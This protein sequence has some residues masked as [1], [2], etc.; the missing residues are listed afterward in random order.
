M[1]KGIKTVDQW[2]TFFDQ[3]MRPATSLLSI[4]C[5]LLLACLLQIL[6]AHPE[7][8]APVNDG[9]D[10]NV[11][12][13]YYTW[14][15]MTPGNINKRDLASTYKKLA[16]NYHPDKNK[17]PEAQDIFNKISTAFY[18]LNDDKQRALYD[19]FGVRAVDEHAAGGG[20]SGFDE[21]RFA[22][23]IY[24]KMFRDLFDMQEF[25]GGRGRRARGP[26]S[27]TGLLVTLEDMFQGKSVHL[28]YTRTRKCSHCKGTGADNPD[29][30]ETCDKCAG[31]GTYMTIQR[32]SIGVIQQL[33]TCDQCQGRGT[34]FKKVCRVC[35]GQR[36]QQAVETVEVKVPIGTRDGDT[37]SFE[38]MAHEEVRGEAGDLIV[39]FREKSH[40][41]FERDGI[42]LY[43]TLPLTVREAL[44]GFSRTIPHLDGSSLALARS[45][46]ITQPGFVERI[47]GAGMPRKDS[48]EER[49]DLF[50]RYEVVLPKALSAEQRV[51][52]DKTFTRPVGSGASKEE[53]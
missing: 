5:L 8:E 10:K 23:D 28:E 49:G 41:R 4:S 32:L 48:P 2:G 42:H 51:L 50:V 16:K 9:F 25:L 27:Q 17:S 15:N 18:V 13:A 43:T 36:L 19:Q 24:S 29:K 20:G 1:V 30:V 52:I 38:G 12:N 53:L 22:Q 39:I 46:V 14:F 37:Q 3:K 44:L 40:G 7:S 31:S 26:D 34:V 6:R 33:V 11:K 45:D 35:Q 47:R 21:T